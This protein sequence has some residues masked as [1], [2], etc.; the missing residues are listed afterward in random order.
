MLHT[1]GMSALIVPE[2]LRPRVAENP[3]V[4]MRTDGRSSAAVEDAPIKD[5]P[6]GPKPASKLQ[7]NSTTTR[8]S[9]NS[10]E[11]EPLE[12][13]EEP[14]TEAPTRPTPQ[15]KRGLSVRSSEKTDSRKK[16]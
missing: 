14:N 13:P 2:H 9:R 1:E 4:G 8:D 10:M 3:P 16:R 12:K 7:R 15:P 11:T 6:R 5:D